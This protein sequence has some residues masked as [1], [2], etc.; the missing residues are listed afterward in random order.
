M[1]QN[2]AERLAQ[3]AP[4]GRGS[5]SAV[6]K[7]SCLLSRDRRKRSLRS[8]HPDSDLAVQ[9]LIRTRNI[10]SAEPDADSVGLH[11]N[12]RI[13]DHFP[14]P[15]LGALDDQRFPRPLHAIRRFRE[16]D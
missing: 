2:E 11:L 1:T 5:E 8:Q 7:I 13:A 14:V 6:P 3:I 9:T 4:C 12:S 16:A 15:R 10:A